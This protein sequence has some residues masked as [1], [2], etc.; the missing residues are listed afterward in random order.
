M[1][2][3]SA[4]ISFLDKTVST[5]EVVIIAYLP[6]ISTATYSKSLLKAQAI[7]EGNVQGVVVHIITSTLPFNLSFILFNTGNLTYTLVEVWFSSYSISA[8]ANAVS[9]SIHQ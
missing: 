9:H 8:A 4:F 5:K 7:F 3:P 2:L 6:P 1:S